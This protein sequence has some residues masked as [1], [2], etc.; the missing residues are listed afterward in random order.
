[1]ADRIWDLIEQREDGCWGWTGGKLQNGYPI[2]TDEQNRQHMAY[3]VVYEQ[4]VGP[5]PAG[6]YVCHHCDTPTCCRPDHLF[7]GS[8]VVNVQDM[9]AKGRQPRGE[10]HGNA[11]LTEACVREMRKLRGY[12]LRLVDIAA[13][14]G[15]S[16]HTVSDVCR[17]KS[18][19]HVTD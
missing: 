6:L 9:V 2:I 3:R 5:I 19:A 14:L 11:V 1:M 4:R 12:G 17:R 7:V 10:R 18:W 15:V 13:E 16:I 8:H